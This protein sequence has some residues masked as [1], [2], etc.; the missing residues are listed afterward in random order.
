MGHMISSIGRILVLATALTTAATAERFEGIGPNDWPG[1][2][3]PTHNGVAAAGQNPPTEWS[4][5]KNILWKTDIPGRGHASPTVVGDFIYLP[6]ADE[7]KQTQSVICLNR[8]TGKLVWSKQVNEGGFD[9]DG[10]KRKSHASASIACDGTRLF[11]N[12]VNHGAMR[13]TALDL[14]GNQIW[15]QEISKFITHQGFG[16]SPFLYQDLVIVCSDNKGGGAVAA[17]NRE[18]GKMIWRNDRPKE[19]NYV[20]PVVF[21]IDGRDQL[22]L[23]GCNLVTCLEP[24]TGETIWEVPGSTTECVVTMVTDGKRVFTSGGY[25]KN[26]TVAINADG[27]GEVAWQN[28]TRVYVPSMI[29]YQEHAFAVAD[30]GF[31]VCWES[32]TGKE[33]WKERLGGDFFSSPVFAGG[34]IYATNIRGMTYVYKADPNDFKIIAKNQLGNEVYSSP[35]ICD[36]RVYLRTAHED[37]QRVEFLYCIGN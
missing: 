30:A 8:H 9:Q 37:E 35:V 18:T 22:F 33:I 11:V 1:W 3:G 12:F 20:S 34:H 28:S 13:T 23:S 5:S 27:S 19:P 16:A 14:K 7:T 31:A 29:I 4:E 25:P 15:Q 36:S 26:H 17:M 10:H 21:N 32:A 6:T 24:S 2:R